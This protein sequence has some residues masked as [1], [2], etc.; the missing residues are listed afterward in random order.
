MSKPAAVL[1]VMAIVAC[2]REA[3]AQTLS[4]VL[5]FLLTN[6]T[7]A[8]DDFVRDQQAAKAA[9]DAMSAFLLINLNTLPITTSAGGFT[10]RFDRTIGASVRSTDSFDPFSGVM[11]R[12][13]LWLLTGGAADV[14]AGIHDYPPPLEREVATVALAARA[15]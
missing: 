11:I 14:T 3:S 7:V 12:G 6:R 10:Y 9:S 8:T 1:V 15:Q 5:S 4:D 13:L 2:G